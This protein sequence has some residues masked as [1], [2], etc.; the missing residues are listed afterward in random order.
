ML[1][2]GGAALLF[3]GAGGYVATALTAQKKKEAALY[4]ELA[5]AAAYF[6][7]EACFAKR[8]VQEITNALASYP[9]SGESFSRVAQQLKN[10]PGEPLAKALEGELSKLLQGHMAKKNVSPL[11]FAAGFLEGSDL[12]A[13]GESLQRAENE[14]RL[15]ESRLLADWRRTAGLYRSVGVVAG[16]F[17]ALMLF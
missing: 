12:T 2:E 4:G 17:A 8:P 16:L 10:A 9:L 15:E 1:L 3:M 13:A 6:R 7:S 11:L 5:Q 14:F